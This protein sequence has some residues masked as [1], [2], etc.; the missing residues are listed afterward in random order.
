M[1]EPSDDEIRAKLEQILPTVDLEST[2]LK[3]FVRI[4]SAAL[5]DDVDLRPRKAFVKQAL[6]EALA[7]QQQDDDEGS[8]PAQVSE[9]N[10]DDEDD[11][12]GASTPKRAAKRG[13]GLSAKKEISEKLQKFLN[14]GDHMARTEV[15]KA[16]WAYIR[17]H[18]L[19]NP[20]NKKEII[21]DDAMKEVFGCDRFTM[22]SMNKY[23]GAHIH[24]FKPVD[25]TTNTTTTATTPRRKRGKKNDGGGSAKKARK[26]GSQP[27]YR[28]SEDMAAVTGTD[29]L[30]R[31]QVV[32]KLWEYIRAHD[33]QNPE[34]RREILCDERLR[35]VLGNRSRVTMFQMNAYITE[36]LLEKVDR[37]AYRHPEASDDE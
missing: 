17:E 18:D 36:H 6:T 28:L 10:D 14:M 37:D 2:G 16:L 31:P 9:E 19:Q 21:L 20:A 35:R 7:K 23:I 27:P 24:P 29:I 26:T 34:D 32:S 30:P 33:L 5:G 11:D 8:D 1:T 25:L 22:F 13:G 12:D 3:K 4:L 15:V